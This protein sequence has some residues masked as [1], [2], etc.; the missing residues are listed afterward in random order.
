LPVVGE[1]DRREWLRTRDREGN[2]A[3]VYEYIAVA[4]SQ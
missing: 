2:P 3:S 1:A 4:N